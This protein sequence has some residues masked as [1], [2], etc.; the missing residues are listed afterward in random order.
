MG[1]EEDRA[2]LRTEGF[3]LGLELMG[4]QWVQP[5]KRLVH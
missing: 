2:A 4:G 1:G 3:H 5:D